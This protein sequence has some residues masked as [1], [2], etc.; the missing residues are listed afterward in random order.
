MTKTTWR[1]PLPSVSP[2]TQRHLL[3]H[4]YGGDQGPKA[5]FQAALHADEIPGMLVLHH[6][7]ELLDRADAANRVLG[8]VVLVPAAN[9]VGMGQRILGRHIGR[10]EAM[11]G[12][13]FNRGHS[14][15]SEQVVSRVK[16]ALG[17]DPSENIRMIRA[18]ALVV[19]SERSVVSEVGA[20]RLALW[21]LAV[22]ADLVFDLHCDFDAVLHMY[23]HDDCWDQAEALHCQIGSEATLLA[24]SSGGEPFD[25]AFSGLWQ[26]LRER[27]PKHPIPFA[28]MSTTLELRGEADVSDE[29]AEGDA[30]NLFRYLQRRGVIEGDPGPLPVAKCHAT[31][32]S[33]LDYL[34]APR[35][36]VIVYH[37]K[38]G[39]PVSK[40]ELVA[41][42]VDP[43][44]E[45]PESARTPVNSTVTG[46]M[47]SRAC[48]RLARPGQNIATLAG[49][50][51][52]EHRIGLLLSD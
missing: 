16:S 23:T 14:N 39:D 52:L 43:M 32:L 49:A 42:L 15:L 8:Q 25:E 51:P 1:V 31:P 46:V 40:G 30:C 20:L 2:G 17:D 11:G 22:D 35:A 6:L 50:E 13:N 10:Y 48:S 24:R 29:S 12:D 18:A 27:F 19:L 4:R 28:C 45:S 33:G 47:M 38:P 3:V 37:K 44:A 41:E 36:G 7:Q 34:K 5:Y 9:P 26:H 21:R